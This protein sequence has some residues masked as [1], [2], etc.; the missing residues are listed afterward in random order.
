M[1]RVP[2][3]T[4]WREWARERGMAPAQTPEETMLM[5]KRAPSSLRSIRDWMSRDGYGYGVSDLLGPV[6]DTDRVFG[7]DFRV[8]EDAEH[9]YA[10]ADAEDAVLVRNKLFL[11]LIIIVSFV[12]S[13]LQPAGC[14]DASLRRLEDL[15]CVQGGRQRCC[16]LRRWSRCSLETWLCLQTSLELRGRRRRGRDVT[17]PCR[18]RRFAKGIIREGF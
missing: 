5:G 13:D 1:A 14:P 8:R 9:F 6:D 18:F 10:G 2:L 17:C 7:F 4:S 11:T 16:P 15:T 12:H 3:P